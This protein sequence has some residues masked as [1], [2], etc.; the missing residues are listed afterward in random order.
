M[1]FFL[2]KFFYYFLSTIT[3]LSKLIFQK[4]NYNNIVIRLSHMTSFDFIILILILFLGLLII[5]FINLP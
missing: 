2:L 3:N 5:T 4:K 1:S